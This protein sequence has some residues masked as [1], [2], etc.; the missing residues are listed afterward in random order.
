MA[1]GDNG[2][3]VIESKT[4]TSNT[5]SVDFQSIPSSYAHLWIVLHFRGTRSAG[6]GEILMTFNNDTSTNYD[7]GRGN[8]YNSQ[9][10]SNIVTGSTYISLGNA[11]ATSALPSG[12]YGVC[13]IF[14]PR[15]TYTGGYRQIIATTG[16]PQSGASL[17]AYRTGTWKNLSSAITSIQFAAELGSVASGSVLSLYGM[18]ES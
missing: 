16:D 15:Y 12:A 11:P 18:V 14:I 17:A 1:V 6:D 8:G 4:L 5:A 2:M 3:Y 9:M 10:Y 7:Y 13:E